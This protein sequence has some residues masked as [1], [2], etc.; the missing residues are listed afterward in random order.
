[1]HGAEGGDGIGVGIGGRLW[2]K[3]EAAV[4]LGQNQSLQVRRVGG[5]AGTYGNSG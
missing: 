1:M 2:S 3:V 4:D 5:R